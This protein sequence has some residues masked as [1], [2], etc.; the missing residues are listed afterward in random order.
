M[1]NTNCG[2]VS[3][4]IN[5]DVLGEVFAAN[6]I[7]DVCF[8]ES[9]DVRIVR[10]EDGLIF[11]KEGG[12]ATLPQLIFIAWSGCGCSEPAD[13]A[14][15]LFDSLDSVFGKV[16]K[17]D[18]R[19]YK[20]NSTYGGSDTD[21]LK[22]I[23][24]LFEKTDIADRL[25]ITE[26][27]ASA[28]GMQLSF[29]TFGFQRKSY[30]GGRLSAWRLNCA[31]EPY[32]EENAAL[33][34]KDG[35]FSA[36]DR[37]GFVWDNAALAKAMVEASGIDSPKGAKV[38]KKLD[39]R[40]VSE[41]T[42]MPVFLE[43]ADGAMAGCTSLNKVTIVKKHIQLGKNIVG[44]GVVLCG[45]EGSSA[46]KYADDNGLTLIEMDMPQPLP[47]TFEIS[48]GVFI[49]ADMSSVFRREDEK[50]SSLNDVYYKPWDGTFDD[51]DCALTELSEED[52]AASGLTAQLEDFGSRI[53]TD[54][55][56][57]DRS[58]YIKVTLMRS[59]AR[60]D[61]FGY[62]MEIDHSG[63]VICMHTEQQFTADELAKGAEKKLYARYG[64]MAASVTFGDRPAEPVIVEEPAI[65][66]TV[67]PDYTEPAAEEV[68]SAPE[69]VAEPETVQPE[70]VEP[71][72][73][74][75]PS[76]PE[77]VAEPEAVQPEYVEPAEVPSAPET[78]AEPETVQH[79]YTE[80]AA[81][82]V[83][84]V[85]EV[86]VE[87]TEAVPTEVEEVAVQAE[88]SEI[89]DVSP[90]DIRPADE[91]VKLVRGA[92]FDLRDFAENML[93]VDM[94][95]QAEAGLDID[96]YLF[97]L[98][99][100]KKVRSDADLVFFGQKASVDRAVNNHPTNTRCFTVELSKLDKDITKLAVAFAIYGDNAEQ[101]FAKVTKPT[102]RISCGGRELCS[103]ELEGLTDERSAVAVEI[104]NKNGWKLRTIGLGY[105]EALKSL[106]GSY[107]V[108]VK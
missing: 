103:Y 9:A 99:E 15:V 26:T 82:Q 102:V 30:V 74:E 41:I 94:D 51:F 87:D 63:R 69:A 59:K 46:E 24:E 101:V 88:N 2:F 20:L 55:V 100:N 40:G 71:A 13:D 93:V 4:K 73:E 3:Y 98:G 10:D 68:P 22:V 42:V 43:I 79:D 84:S 49:T 56:R 75:V 31:G 58:G 53:D 105:K 38:L 21:K 61:V 78:V 45:F 66:E 23:A 33:L 52:A 62:I 96:G 8:A 11:A 29:G 60:N 64:Q 44:P 19:G 108:E 35:E 25:D 48:D 77:T 17:A 86:S 14:A 57:N 1:E 70:Y 107:G 67:Q 81:E 89:I 106:C 91:C 80:P 104:Y 6:G 72:A 36:A 97:L 76:A 37:N 83:T 18:C 90:D 34:L 65:I 32:N 50:L 47:Y 7:G 16:G 95:Y 92:R 5:E 28:E 39:C 54:T 12:D 27:R 85:T